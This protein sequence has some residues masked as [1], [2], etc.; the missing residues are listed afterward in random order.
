MRLIVYPHD[1]EM[2]GSQ[3]NAIDL[4]AEMARLG[5]DVFVYGLHRPLSDYIKAKGLPFIA[6]NP[7]AARP[8]PQRM[9]ELLRLCRRERID[10]VHA[11][12]WPPCLDTYYGAHL[13]G[14][15]PLVCTVL[16]MSVSPLV[17]KTV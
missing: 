8:S 9:V 12:E 14:R 10:I 7:M 15:V 11:Y 6:A 1:L 16:S 3:I 4:A 13:V 5:H 17:P 2:G